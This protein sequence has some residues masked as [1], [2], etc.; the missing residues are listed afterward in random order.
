MTEQECQWQTKIWE[1][2]SVILGS[3]IPSRSSVFISDDT[4]G[5]NVCYFLSVVNSNT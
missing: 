3:C 5:K 4:N 2:G 1:N